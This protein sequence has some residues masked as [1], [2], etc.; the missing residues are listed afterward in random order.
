MIKRVVFAALAIIILLG[1]AAPFIH[2]DRYG[3]QIRDALQRGLNRKVEIGAVQFNLF[4]GPGFTIENVVIYD[5]PSAGLEP[6]AHML[7]LEARVGL[8]S[9]FTGQLDFSVLRFVSPSVNIVKPDTGAWNV[10]RLLQGAKP[11]QSL[12]E[13][14]V[15]D[16]RIYLKTGDTKSAFYIA[17]ADITVTPRR[18]SLYVRFSGEPARTDRSAR[19]TGLLVAKGT[20]AAGK[21]DMD[22]ELESSPVNEIGGLFRGQ[23]LEYHGTIASRAKLSGPL[24]KLDVSGSFNLSDVHRWD[25]MTEHDRSWTVNYK[26][27][28]DF[29]NQRINLATSNSPNT[30]RLVVSDLMKQPEWAVDMSVNELAAST[31]VGV[32]RDMGA[33]M[34]KGVLVDGRVVGMVGYGSRSGLQGQLRVNDGSVQLQDGPQLKLAEASLLI[35]GDSIELAPAALVGEEGQGAQLEGAYNSATRTLDATISGHGLRLLSR[36]AIPLV[37]RFQG[38]KWSAALRYRQTDVAPGL[39]TGSF[40]VRDTTTHVPGV[41]QPV[42]IATARIEINGD[43]L[44]VRQMRAVAGNVELYGSYAYHPADPRPHRF[45]FTVPK[46]AM[47]DVERLLAPSMRRDEGFFARTLRLRR[48]ASPEWLENRKAEG[49]IRIGV[50]SAGD[51]V[52]RGVRSRVVWDG[53]V[54]QLTSLEGRVEDGSFKGSGIVDI[55]KSEPQYKLLGRV[56]NVS[57]KSGKVDLEGELQTLGSGLELLLNLRGEGTFLAHGVV[58]S[59]DQTVRAAT[60]AFGLSITPTGLQFKLSDVQASLGSERFTGDGI[61]LADGRLQMELA[62]ANRTV[63]VNVDSAR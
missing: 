40:D 54:V 1:I 13:I 61:T 42:R 14:Q 51:T 27:A 37:D 36:A 48:A 17:S 24:S 5:D 52:A 7:E 43:A 44:N 56:Q 32:A 55:T 30:L 19:T 8:S 38:G 45:D 31:L 9:L 15:T 6:F 23:R 29:A 41:A 26:G 28:V 18:D 47:A 33:P 11:A 35:A 22:L 4:T 3:E 16:G 62:S 34:P 2:A 20:I 21:V 12:P 57:W 58:L 60:G 50:L 39:W 59:P 25:R 10:V 53:G 46:A 63:R 49:Q